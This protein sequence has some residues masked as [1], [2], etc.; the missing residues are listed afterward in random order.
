MRITTNK[1]AYLILIL[2]AMVSCTKE[3]DPLPDT[4]EIRLVDPENM[5]IKRICEYDK[6]GRILKIT[7]ST[8]TD[9]IE[10]TVYTYNGSL[11]EKMDWTYWGWYIHVQF[12]YDSIN[13]ILKSVSSDD[14]S[15][16]TSYFV[17]NEDLTINY[18]MD[19]SFDTS[20]TYIYDNGKLIARH[21]VYY[22][23]SLSYDQRGN[24]IK[25]V[26]YE[27]SS[28]ET[29]NYYY[30][31]LNRF[32]GMGSSGISRGYA[33]NSIGLLSV[34]YVTGMDEDYKVQYIA[35]QNRIFNPMDMKPENF[36]KYSY[37]RYNAIGY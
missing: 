2:L 7:D 33:Y 22:I 14:M 25:R 4:Y 37:F 5:T 13:R 32:V 3:K 34:I 28:V 19:A 31:D 18:L 29:T 1:N 26:K 8:D 9:H 17:L 15:S 21:S 30:D 24:L 16:Y 23:D 12:E 6:E 35:Y 36:F 11:P 27:G 10:S 20:W